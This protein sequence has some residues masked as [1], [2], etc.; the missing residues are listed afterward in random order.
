MAFPTKNS[1]L[2]I[3]CYEKVSQVFKEKELDKRSAVKICQAGGSG[4]GESR[5]TALHETCMG[6]Q[7]HTGT[8]I[9]WDA[10]KLF[11][12]ESQGEGGVQEN[13]SG[14]RI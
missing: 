2:S 11:W 6:V 5:R 13:S 10:I 4:E 9:H 8:R 14:I 1:S 12:Y 3:I 7:V